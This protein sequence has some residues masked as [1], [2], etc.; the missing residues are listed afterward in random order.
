MTALVRNKTGSK[1]AV[2]RD[3]RPL[4]ADAK[5]WQGALAACIIS[6]TGKGYYA[7]ADD[8]LIAV[9][10][11]RFVESV[12]NTGGAAGALSAQV[13]FFR[14]RWLYLLANDTGTPVVV[15]DRESNCYVLDDQ[16]VSGTVS[17]SI[18]GPV[19]DVVSE[20]VWVEVGAQTASSF[21]TS[22]LS[23][24]APV[25]PSSTAASAGS[26]TTAMRSD[27]KMHIALATPTTEGLMS[28]AQASAVHAP[29]AD[30]T[31][32]AAIAAA[33]RSAGML[34]LVLSDIAGEMSLWRFHATSTAADTSS[35][36]VKAPAV[37]SGRWL[38]ANTTVSL[39]L[40]IGFGT[41]DNAT[42]FTVPVGARLHPREAWWEIATS[43]SGGTGTPSIGLHASPTGWSTKGD[44]LG[45]A[46]GDVNATLVSTNTRMVGTIGAKLDTRTNG[47]LILIAADTLN[48]DRISSVATAGAGAARVLCDVLANPGA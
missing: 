47:R 48:Y 25:D 5:V 26:A 39:Y 7:P 43:Y 40:P 30:L 1:R 19:Y 42:L 45:G 27:A 21:D 20:G 24:V 8:S 2:D 18:A 13:E 23:N 35:N 31:A 44:I 17:T 33:D 4:A 36:L 38:R 11:G 15:A 9:T 37:G 41:A 6:G 14:E 34:C 29:V 22:D 3:K 28:A 32:L 46:A 12:D 10:V 16:T